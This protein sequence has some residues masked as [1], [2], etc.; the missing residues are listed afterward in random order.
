[1]E[2]SAL[3]AKG[4]ISM[5]MSLGHKDMNLATLATALKKKP[6]SSFQKLTMN[7]EWPSLQNKLCQF[8]GA[9]PAHAQQFCLEYKCPHCHL[10][11]PEH[12]PQQCKRQ[13]RKPKHFLKAKEEPVSP[14]TLNWDYDGYYEIEGY[15]DRNLNREN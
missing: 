7:P 8:C 15:E 3:N 5:T 10:Y 2:K 13:P 4:N 11:T 14:E 12:L 1:M 6:S 9:N